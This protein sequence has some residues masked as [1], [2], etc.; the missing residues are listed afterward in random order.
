MA[1]RSAGFLTGRAWFAD[2]PGPSNLHESR[3]LEES[4]STG[5]GAKEDLVNDENAA[6][7]ADVESTDRQ[8]QEVMQKAWTEVETIDE[9]LRSFKLTGGDLQTLEEGRSKLMTEMRMLKE[10]HREWRARLPTDQD[11]PE[12]PGDH[13]LEGRGRAE[14]NLGGFRAQ[15]LAHNHRR[16]TPIRPRFPEPTIRAAPINEDPASEDPDAEEVFFDEDLAVFTDEQ[17]QRADDWIS[18]LPSEF[19]WQGIRPPS[20]HVVPLLRPW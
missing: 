4:L 13:S 5:R 17:R 9:A 15:I 2:Q 20:P 8:I 3:E 10:V 6:P 1:A 12:E 18:T 11:E 16:Q 7:N 19:V 14:S